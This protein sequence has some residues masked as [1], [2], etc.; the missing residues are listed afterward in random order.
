M[1]VFDVFLQAGLMTTGLVVY[2]IFIRKHTP[3]RKNYSEPGWNYPLKWLVA[4]YY[5]VKTW[6]ASCPSVPLDE[7]PRSDLNDGWD[8]I[9]ITATTPDGAA[10]LLG[11]RKI[12]GRQPLAEV[13]LYV[14]L[15]DGTSY[16]LSRHPDTVVGV[17]EDTPECW[18]AGGLKIQVVEPQLCSRVIFNGIMTRL[19]DGVKQHATMNFIWRSGSDV[20]RF[21]EDWS[22]QLAAHTLALEQWRDDEW[23]NILGK[24]EEG[25]WMQYGVIQGR[26]QS[27]DEQGDIDRSEYLRYRGVR[28]RMWAPH[29]YQGVRRSVTMTVMAKDG[30]AVRIRGTSYSN[31]L[32]ETILGCV[33]HPDVEVHSITGTDFAL[34]NFCETPDEIPKM[35]TFHVET[36]TREFRVVLSIK[37]G[38][39]LFSGVPYQQDT[40]YRYV[41]GLINGYPATGMLVLGYEAAEHSYPAY[42]IPEARSLKWLSAEEAGPASYCLK[43]EDRAAKCVDYVGGKGA[44]LALLASVQEAE[45]YKVPPGFCLTTLALEKHLEMNPELVSA[46]KEIESANENYEESNFKAKCNRATQ[47]FTT[48]EIVGAVKDDILNYLADLRIKARNKGLEERFAVRSSAVGEDSE[49]LSA[50]GQNETILGCVSDEDVLRGVQKCWGSMFAFTSAYYRRQNGQPCLCGGA[51][52][53]Q[54]LVSPRAAGVLFSR[55]PARGDAAR[56]LLTANYGLGESVVSG[57]VE[58]DTITVR[59]HEDGDMS[60]MKIELGSKTERVTTADDGVTSQSVPESERNVPCLSESEMLQLARLGGRQEQ[61]WGAGRDI[62]WAVAK[63]GIYLLQ[64]RPIT[65]LEQWTEEELLHEHDS[66]IM[67]DDDIITFA[68]CGEVMP[69]PMSPLSID[70]LLKPLMDT[71]MHGMEPDA[72]PYDHWAFMTHYRVTMALYALSYRR[73]P[74][75]IDIGVRMQEMALHGHKFADQHI[76]DTALHRRPFSMTRRLLMIM[77]ALLWPLL[78]SKWQL[79]KATQTVK[80][81]PCSTENMSSL[82]II[83][84]ISGLHGH[85]EDVGLRHMYTSS[86]SSG[87]QLIAMSVLLEGRGIDFSQEQCSEIGMMLSSGDVL[88]A[89]V[90]QVLAKLAR[91]IHESGKM[92]EFKAQEPKKAMRWLEETLPDVYKNVVKFLDEHGFRAIMEFDV[93]TKPWV[94]VPE[95]LMK[96]LASMRAAEDVKTSKTDAQIIASLKTPQRS[97]TR[98]ILRLLLPVCRHMVRN[99]EATK[100]QLILAVHKIR[101]MAI[102]LGKQLVK[103][104]YLPDPDLV[105]Y[106]RENE[107]RRYY[108]TRDPALLR[109]A[110]QRQQYFP[111]WSKLR[112]AENHTGWPKPIEDKGPAVTAGDVRVEATS[113]FGGEVIG[114]A[115]VVKDLSEIH[116][117]QQG[118]ILIT[119]ATDIGWSPYFPLL[120]GIVTELGGLISHGAVIAREYGLPCVVGATGATDLFSTGD[121]VRL[122]GHRGILEKVTVADDPTNEM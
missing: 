87:S 34:P 49:T 62:E 88:S 98:K 3:T 22:D 99:R 86:A 65:S 111:K 54:A 16:V 80:N 97:S 12:C 45:G 75:K 83:E 35:F 74:K 38:G 52:V 81:M 73:P 39:R 32:T 67:S 8:S 24:W 101:L 103:E 11:V 112:F 105:F 25:S 5:A 20:S 37:D 68:N 89:E 7:L 95:E 23:P 108:Q 58:P 63:D 104:W 43:F 48:T 31:V 2:L 15:T 107:L 27:Y 116:Q 118:D 72:S 44:S 57:T 46:I 36:K 106:F 18:S 50:A 120:S 100:A 122:L 113:V 64:A 29:G 96:V 110:I 26:F 17:W 33:R 28:E 9:S 60:I 66:P 59:R 21:P 14:K 47:L 109:K 79:K 92:E 71:L 4:R 94:L 53:V 51:V 102:Q 91:Q 82:E 84:A 93:A 119:L 10:V 70:V 1:D 76:I 30:T 85:M 42:P 115:C 56:L 121:T 114:R 117:L 78:S 19:S 55:H 90:P 40:E 41:E 69:K 6:K 13:V 61:L 77:R